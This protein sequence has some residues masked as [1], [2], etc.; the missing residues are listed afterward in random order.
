MNLN[1]FKM[2]R[3]D[4][5]IKNIF[6]FPGVLLAILYLET[7]DLS[8]L[9]D[10]FLSFSASCFIASANYLINEWLDREHDKLHPNNCNR[11][12]ALGLVNSKGVL[13]YYVGLIII[14]LMLAFSVGTDV[15]GAIIVFLL[16]GVIYNVKP[17]RAKDLPY[18]D[19]IVES[20]NNPVRFYIGWLS[21]H[22][23][24]LIPLS[25]ILAYWTFGAFLMTCKR[26]TDYRK[27]DN[28]KSRMKFR[29]SLGKYSLTS[30]SAGA[31][32]YACLTSSLYAAFSVKYKFELI[33]ILPLLLTS[34]VLYFVNS[35]SKNSIA[36]NPE[37]IWHSRNFVGLITVF[38]IAFLVLLKID[39][40]Y[41]KSYF[42]MYQL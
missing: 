11:P 33:L 15:L 5:W 29:P 39:L 30:L 35:N 31:F 32:T 26:I 24:I 18:L 25:L 17:I 37:K 19:V 9:L 4:H 36:S 42:L 6:V 8:I 7:I 2:M 14:G 34:L 28:S 21:V 22:D 3:F 38:S 27:F 1:Y 40:P 13:L 12:A 10:I 41:L 16:S 20:F 23:G